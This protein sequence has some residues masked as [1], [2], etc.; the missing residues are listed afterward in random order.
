MNGQQNNFCCELGYSVYK[1][2]HMDIGLAPMQKT[3][4]SW[5]S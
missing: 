5:K 4:E 1:F 3:F 2:M